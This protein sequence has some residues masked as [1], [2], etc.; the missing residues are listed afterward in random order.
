MQGLKSNHYNKY[1]TNKQNN[2]LNCKW[3]TF[4]FGELLEGHDM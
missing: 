4:N 2:L 3:N 1:L